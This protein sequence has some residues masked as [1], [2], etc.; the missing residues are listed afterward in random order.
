MIK[1]FVSLLSGHALYHG[2]VHV[3]YLNN[4]LCFYALF[5]YIFTLFNDD[6]IT[7]D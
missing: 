4:L 2:C 3:N 1:I 5:T 7:T 6:R